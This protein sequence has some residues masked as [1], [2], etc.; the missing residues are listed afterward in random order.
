[1]I[2]W[3]ICSG[4]FLPRGMVVVVEGRKIRKRRRCVC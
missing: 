3:S 2:V 4:T 1:M